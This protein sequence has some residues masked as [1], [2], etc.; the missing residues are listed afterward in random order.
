MLGVIW[1]SAAL[2]LGRYARGIALRRLPVMAL[3]H[4]PIGLGEFAVILACVVF[5]GW[6]FSPRQ[7]RKR[8]RDQ[9][10]DRAQLRRALTHCTEITHKDASAPSAP[11][12]QRANL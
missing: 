8:R 3:L 10:R 4:D 12:H 11:H 1:A 7:R 6:W 5:H 9:A 2:G